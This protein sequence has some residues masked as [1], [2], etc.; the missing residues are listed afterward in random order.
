N[1]VS[2]A[3][4]AA[5]VEGVESGAWV[6]RVDAD[7]AAVAV[8]DIRPGGDKRRR[9]SALEEV[10]AVV[11]A[12]GQDHLRAGRT[13]GDAGDLVDAQAGG[14]EGLPAAEVF[15]GEG[16]R[17]RRQIVGIQAPDAAVVAVQEPADPVQHQGVVVGV[18]ADLVAGRICGEVGPG[19]ATVGAL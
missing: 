11:L 7:E 1:E 18:W 17:G 8:G 19:G 9:L 3:R 16:G 13:E 2:E 12:A 10:G 14:V 15:P 4:A 6:A 5:V